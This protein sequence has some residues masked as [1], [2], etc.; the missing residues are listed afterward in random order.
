MQKTVWC[1]FD[2]HSLALSGR[3][4]IKCWALIV[5]LVFFGDLVTVL[6]ATEFFKKYT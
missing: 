2:N 5:L 4:V 6:T 3:V 1:L